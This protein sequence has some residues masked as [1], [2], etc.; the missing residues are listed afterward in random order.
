M[1]QMPPAPLLHPLALNAFSHCC[2]SLYSCGGPSRRGLPPTAIALAL[3]AV[4]TPLRVYERIRY[5]DALEKHRMQSPPIFILGHWRTGTTRLHELLSLNPSLGFV[6]TFQTIVPGSCMVSA[7]FFL[8]L[9]RASMPS[10]RPMDNVALG[11]GLPQEEEVAI[12][13]L[14]A[15]SYYLGWYFPSMLP[16][17]FDKYVLMEGLSAGELEKWQQIYSAVVQKASFLAGGRRLVLKNP[18]NTARIP[19]MLA[20][21]PGAKFVY[22][23]RDPFE[24]YP[25]TLNFYEKNLTLLSLQDF[26]RDDCQALALRHY[27]P[28]IGRYRRD[29]QRVP[30]GDLIEITFED[31]DNSPLETIARVHETLGLEDW[32]RTRSIL[33][34]HINSEPPHVRNEF[35]LDDASRER[36]QRHWITPLEGTDHE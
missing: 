26:S 12:A 5:Q 23:S 9:I 8:P 3:S 4:T 10:K 21:Y 34:R 32:P 22:L 11:A 7:P 1:P 16:Q 24:V 15:C 35:A 36:V 2:A 27:A 28:L 6:S 29:R 14:A 19:Q 25:S 33:E 30:A 20:L 17:L 31:L 18:V 13:N